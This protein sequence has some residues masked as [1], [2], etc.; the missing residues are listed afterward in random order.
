MLNG[1]SRH[2]QDESEGNGRDQVLLT[3]TGIKNELNLD[4]QRISECSKNVLHKYYNR[5]VSRLAM[6]LNRVFIYLKGSLKNSEV[7]AAWV[8]DLPVSRAFREMLC[9]G[10]DFQLKSLKVTI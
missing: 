8:Q 9:R 4:T 7:T 1:G 6:I 3:V 10:Y 2:I 5:Y